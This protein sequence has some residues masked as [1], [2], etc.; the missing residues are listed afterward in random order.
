MT[1]C[2]PTHDLTGTVDQ[3]CQIKCKGY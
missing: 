2:N 1:Q 3:N